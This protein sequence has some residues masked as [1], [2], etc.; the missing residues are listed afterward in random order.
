VDTAKTAVASMDVPLIDVPI[1][2]AAP[3]PAPAPT[4]VAS[5]G[6]AADVA[7]A[8]AS[9]TDAAD[10][11]IP[12]ETQRVQ[13][14]LK[15]SSAITDDALKSKIYDACMQRIQLLSNLRGLIEGSGA[16]SRLADFARNAKSEPERLIFVGKLFGDDV[17]MH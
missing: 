2:G 10:N 7:P 17:K 13:N 12:Y 6:G 3:A 5:D 16:R 14:V 9:A 15:A 1:A 4:P 11:F 8:P